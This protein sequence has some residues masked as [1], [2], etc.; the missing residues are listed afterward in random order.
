MMILLT[1]IGDEACKAALL[2]ISLLFYYTVIWT[3]S[4]HISFFSFF[5]LSSF[6][7]PLKGGVA[8]QIELLK[9]MF[10]LT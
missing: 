2:G 3:A 8:C 10:F 9:K 4:F 7:I 1:M 5:S 6:K